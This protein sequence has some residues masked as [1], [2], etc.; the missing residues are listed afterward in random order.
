MNEPHISH[1]D[2]HCQMQLGVNWNQSNVTRMSCVSGPRYIW[3]INQGSKWGSTLITI[4]IDVVTAPSEGV[5]HWH[6][7]SAKVDDIQFKMWNET[8]WVPLRK[9]VKH[10]NG[11]ASSSAVT[12]MMSQNTWCYQTFADYKSWANLQFITMWSSTLQVDNVAALAQKPNTLYTKYSNTKQGSLPT[13]KMISH[14]WIDCTV[15]CHLKISHKW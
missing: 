5:Q 6:E 9:R 15:N 14:G 4:N 2:I 1:S 3:P 10:S 13:L 8:N 11:M 12:N 7:I